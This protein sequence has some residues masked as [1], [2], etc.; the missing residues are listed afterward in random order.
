MYEMFTK[1]IP[2]PSINDSDSG[3]MEGRK[4]FVASEYEK[5]GS[6]AQYLGCRG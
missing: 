4:R 5:G 6:H 2:K 3:L 1:W